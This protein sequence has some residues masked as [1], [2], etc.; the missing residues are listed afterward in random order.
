MYARNGVKLRPRQGARVFL[1]SYTWQMSPVMGVSWA[2]FST[3][4]TLTG[5]H[6]Q[7]L[8]SI[9]IIRGGLK[10]KPEI[11]FKVIFLVFISIK[12]MYILIIISFYYRLKPIKRYF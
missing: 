7:T 1:P 5:L 11:S 9:V 12:I 8:S 4:A 2:V 6:F 3:H 10:N